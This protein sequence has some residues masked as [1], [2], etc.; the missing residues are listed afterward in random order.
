MPTQPHT[1]PSEHHDPF[2]DARAVAVDLLIVVGVAD[3]AEL[4]GAIG[5]AVHRHELAMQAAERHP[6]AEWLRQRAIGA[7]DV[8]AAMGASFTP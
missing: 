3:A 6:G 2:V 1:H 8:V 5:A 4:A 7:A